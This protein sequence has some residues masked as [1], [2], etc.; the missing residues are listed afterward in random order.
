VGLAGKPHAAARK[1]PLG[2]IGTG[3]ADLQPI[4][5]QSDRLLGKRRLI[6]PCEERSDAAIQKCLLNQYA[7]LLRCARNDVIS[8]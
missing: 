2:E 6:R 7:G 3:H 8:N 1:I 5:F 4:Y